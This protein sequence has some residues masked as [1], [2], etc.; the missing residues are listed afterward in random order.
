[1]N[2]VNYSCYLITFI[3]QTEGK[4]KCNMDLSLEI[5]LVFFSKKEDQI[6]TNPSV[7]DK[8]IR[9]PH[10]KSFKQISARDLEFKDSKIKKK[11][12]KII[13]LKFH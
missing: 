4:V 7:H 11:K 8:P 1:M 2:K 10:T 12:F 6:K 13:S 9:S 3:T 5:L